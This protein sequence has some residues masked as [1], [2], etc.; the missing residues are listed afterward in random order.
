[1]TIRSRAFLAPTFGVVAGLTGL[2]LASSAARADGIEVPL[3]QVRI[4]TFNGPV[5][6]VFVGNPVI[7]DITVIDPTHVFILGKNF[8]TTNVVALDAKGRET[9]NEQ[10]TVLERPG[11]TVTLQRGAGRVTLNCSSA[12]CEA[13]PTPGDDSE[14]YATVSGQIDNRETASIKAASGQ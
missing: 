11:S 9:V 6:T 4:L 8:G 3:D 2:L 12:R 10:I 13:T 5:K 1:M 14:R 7:A